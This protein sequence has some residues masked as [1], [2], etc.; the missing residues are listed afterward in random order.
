MFVYLDSWEYHVDFMVLTPNNNL[1][2][3]PLIHSRPWLARVDAF[4]SCRFGDMYIFYG[5]S[6]KRFTLYPPTK[7]ITDVESEVWIDDDNEEF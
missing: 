2:G 6:T 3:H 7:I 4:L 1:G 5:S